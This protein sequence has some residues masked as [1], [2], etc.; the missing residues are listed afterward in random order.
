MRLLGIATR[1][2]R[3]LALRSGAMECLFDALTNLPIQFPVKQLWIQALGRYHRMRKCWDARWAAN[4]KAVLPFK[5]NA[6]AV[7]YAER[8]K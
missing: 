5:R 7:L 4:H 3:C 1:R 2:P 6:E 8:V